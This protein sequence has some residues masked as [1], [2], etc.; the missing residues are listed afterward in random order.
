M[1]VAAWSCAR[2]LPVPAFVSVPAAV[3]AGTGT[4][5]LLARWIKMEEYGHVMG[6]FLRSQPAGEALNDAD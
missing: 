2:F 4:Y 3:L 6:V 5:L 1:A